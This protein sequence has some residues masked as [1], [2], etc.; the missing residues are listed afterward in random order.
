MI[1]MQQDTFT[2]VL[3]L[4]VSELT[5]AFSWVFLFFSFSLIYNLPPFVLS[6]Q[7]VHCTLSQFLCESHQSF[8][9][10]PPQERNKK[11]SKLW[12]LFLGLL[13]KGNLREASSI[14]DDD[15]YDAVYRV[16]VFS[17]QF[18]LSLFTSFSLLGSP[19]STHDDPGCQGL[20]NKKSTSTIQLLVGL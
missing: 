20:A 11:E 1:F 4:H 15:D 10:R 19:S 13:L 9:T 7:L 5:A 8:I 6:F 2:L 17:L 18:S 16:F 12:I 14:N 3:P